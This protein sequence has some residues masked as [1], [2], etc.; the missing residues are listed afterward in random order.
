[1]KIFQKYYKWLIAFV[2]CV[3]VIAVYKTF[4]NIK[5]I[6]NVIGLCVKA[7][8]PFLIGF[9]IAYLLNIPTKKLTGL[10]SKI[11]LNYIKK[12]A[13]GIS[14]LTVYL[15][16]FALIALIIGMVVPA[17]SR[18]IIDLSMNLPGYAGKVIA[19]LRNSEVFGKLKVFENFDIS[20]TIDK[21]ISK[22]NTEKFGTYIQGIF[23]MTSGIVSTFIAVISSV[24][25]LL[26]KDRIIELSKK[27]VK[28]FFKSERAE[29]ILKNAKHINE[30]FTS[31]IYCRLWCSI[32]MAFVCTIT[33]SVM[34]V[35]Y[36]VILGLF[37]GAMDMIP[38]FGSIIS[39][40]IAEIV[41]LIT[42]GVWKTVWSTLAL[43]IL[44]QLDGNLLA[45]KIMGISLDMRPL[46][47]IVVV[48]VGGSLF[49]FLGMLISV[50]V[51]AVIRTIIIDFVTEYEEKKKL[52]QETGE[53]D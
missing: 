36:A 17:L 23:D 29:N 32:I 27:T 14:I 38:Y 28:I 16:T 44:Q 43:L 34:K 9:A 22:I 2:F 30:V 10:I 12:H 3:A 51:A 35:R 13:Y 24:Y 6:W 20:D 41:I 48:T 18:N 47:I 11:K 4:D 37:I 49:G 39:V 53:T 15:I 31:Y 8:S 40:V 5:V 52:R 19:K 50:P 42:G 25:M 33:L 1:L 21:F 26:D 45:P 7:V 46:E